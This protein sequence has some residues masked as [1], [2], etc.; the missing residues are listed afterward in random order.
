[1]SKLKDWLKNIDGKKL[2]KLATFGFGILFIVVVSVV[3]AG[4]DPS[5]FD[6]FSWLSSTLILVGIMIYGLIMGESIGGDR[7]RENPNG[8]YQKNLSM[9]NALNK[10]LEPIKNYF[11]Q[12][13]FIIVKRQIRAKKIDYLKSHGV[14]YEWCEIIVDK[15]ALKDIWELKKEEGLLLKVDDEEIVIPYQTPEQIEAIEFV[16]SGK[17][18]IKEPKPTYYLNAFDTIN[19]TYE[20]EE[21]K[22]LDSEIKI[23]KTL[24]RTFKILLSILISVFWA[25]LTVKDFMGGDDP[26]ARATAW[27]N[28]VS[29]IM[30]LFTSFASGWSSSVIDTKL[31]ARKLKGK[32]DM[33]NRYK[34]AYESKEF[35]PMSKKELAK[36]TYNEVKQKQAEVEVVDKKETLLLEEKPVIC[37]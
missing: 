24:N 12:F 21:P 31:R 36:K 35:V 10:E 32:Y 23:N 28:L 7:Q 11:A 1:M 15:L 3:D 33:L 20:L 27:N 8:L 22:H 34:Y 29:R 16:L 37:L 13:Y 2:I 25:M 30:A 5:K 26:I 18:I 6:F 14:D 4:I 17:V 19:A 9:Y